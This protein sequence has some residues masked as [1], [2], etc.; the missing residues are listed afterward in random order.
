MEIKIAPGMVTDLYVSPDTEKQKA[1]PQKENAKNKTSIF[2]N[3]LGKKW[4]IQKKTCFFFLMSGPY[5]LLVFWV[6]V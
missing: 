2:S 5:K 6:R 1:S 3:L 4:K